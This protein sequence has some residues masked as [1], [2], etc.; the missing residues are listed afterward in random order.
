MKLIKD[1]LKYVVYTFY[2][3]MAHSHI[4]VIHLLMELID[5][6]LHSCLVI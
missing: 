2:M 5:T 1:L 3:D 4:T 6:W